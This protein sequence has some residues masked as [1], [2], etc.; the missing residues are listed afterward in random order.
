MADL[1]L[2]LP[3]AVADERFNAFAAAVEADLADSD[4][5]LARL[6]IWRLHAVDDPALLTQLAWQFH[7]MGVEGWDYAAGTEQRRALVENAI[8]LHRYKGT[9]WAVRAALASAIGLGVAIEE[10]DAFRRADG[11][12]AT[13]QIDPGRVLSRPEA[14]SV[15]AVAAAWAPARS[16]LARLYHGYDLRAARYDMPMDRR[17]LYDDWT[18]VDLDGVRQSFRTVHAA[19]GLIAPPECAAGGE[20]VYGLRF[21]RDPLRRWDLW[22]LDGAAEPVL[23]TP[24]Q[25]SVQSWRG[26]RPDGARATPTRW[27]LPMAALADGV[28]Y[29]SLHGVFDGWAVVIEDG[30]SPRYDG[31][32]TYDAG[33]AWRWLTADARRVD[34]SGAAT[35]ARDPSPMPTPALTVETAIHFSPNAR[36]Q[37]WDAAD[38]PIRA[39]R[40]GRGDT[41]GEDFGR[42]PASWGA[43]PW[44]DQPWGNS[45]AGVTMEVMQ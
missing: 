30:E 2:P 16:Q 31:A 3:P 42:R 44:L 18:G 35:P 34:A 39:G 41:T 9:P 19:A 1:R 14:R 6:L 32:A 11:H 45:S 10:A 4:G 36:V 17:C 12:W 26:S 7:V 37:C 24:A 27:V 8:E 43:G 13:Y 21:H 23:A 33:S 20:H 28:P 38:A 29:D 5:D 22:P 25:M 15:A 40:S